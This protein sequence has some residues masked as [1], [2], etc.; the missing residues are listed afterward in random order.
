MISNSL[1][2]GID[3]N[4]KCIINLDCEQ[5]N[6]FKKELI[7]VLEEGFKRLEYSFSSL[8]FKE[9]DYFKYNEICSCLNSIVKDLREIKMI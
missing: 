5:D 1:L 8:R 6:N 3:L 7:K 2:N 9:E 4:H